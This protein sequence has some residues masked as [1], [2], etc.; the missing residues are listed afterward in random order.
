MLKIGDFSKLAHVTVK[1]LRYYDEL[2][3][4]KPV[5]ND[6]YSGYRYYSLEQ[7]PRLNRILALKDLG[8]SLDQIRELLV[9]DLPPGRLRALFNQKQAELQRRLLEEHTR[10]DR[11]EHRLREIE[12]EGSLPEYEVTLKSIPELRV[13]ATR[14]MARHDELPQAFS[15]MRLM[16]Q[17]YVTQAGLRVVG[18]WMV[19]YHSPDYRE[20]NLDVEVAL[21]LGRSALAEGCA[22]PRKRIASQTGEVPSPYV[23]PSPYEVPSPCEVPSP[24]EVPSTRV[25]LLPAVEQVASCLCSERGNL[26]EAY[27]ALYAWT[28]L[29]SYQA[30]TPVRELFLNDRA[31]EPA[32][33]P[34]GALGNAVRVT[35]A[36]PETEQEALTRYTEI[37]I[38]VKSNLIYK[39]K[40]FANPYRKETEMEPTFVNL[41]TFTVVGMRY[42]GKNENQEIHAMWEEA[43]KNFHKVK[44]VSKQAAYGVCQNVPGAAAGEFEYVAGLQV[45]KVEDV[46]TGMVVRQVPMQ[47]Y[48]VFTHVGALDKLRETYNYIYQVWLPKSG[49]KLTGGPDFEFYNEDFKDFAPDSRFYIYVPLQE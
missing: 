17:Q 35:E 31:D 21:V 41:P 37:Q 15:Q 44:N 4:L 34:G 42:F 1:T 5:W 18:P 8:F 36:L 20:R 29:C 11:V 25:R 45:S 30:G 24:D 16:V 48:A 7:L 3:L 27:T 47:K 38:P 6:R 13:A 43:N 23:I 39:E 32:Y 49:Y 22:P 19:V 28:E 9:E 33:D 12:K 46:P 10:L 26:A 14:A 40:F 2:G